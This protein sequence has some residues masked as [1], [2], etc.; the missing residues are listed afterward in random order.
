MK[1]EANCN[2]FPGL[3]PRLYFDFLLALFQIFF[4]LI[5]QHDY[6]GLGLAVLL[7]KLFYQHFM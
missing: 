7:L 1:I 4:F 6:F 5:S 3:F 2:L